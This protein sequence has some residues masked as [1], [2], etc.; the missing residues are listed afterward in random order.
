[1]TFKTTSKLSA[2][3][4]LAFAS[5]SQAATLVDLDITNGIVPGT[6]ISYTIED[7]G[8]TPQTIATPGTTDGGIWSWNNF[9]DFLSASGYQ[10]LLVHFSAPLEISRLVLGATSLSSSA[11][12]V[13]FGGTTTTADFNLSDGLQSLTGPTGLLSYNGATGAFT[14]TGTNQSLMIGSNSSKTITDFSLT[15]TN[16][17]DAYSLFFGFTPAAVPAPSSLV[18]MAIGGLAF[19]RRRQTA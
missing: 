14:N 1:M 6:S 15:V 18:L 5:Q 11:Q 2:F 17:P 8:G 19:F 12:L 16:N 10:E 3:L 7:T 13:L 4:L 9:D